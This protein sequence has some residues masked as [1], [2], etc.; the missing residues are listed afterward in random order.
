MTA[1]HDVRAI[2]GSLW[3]GIVAAYPLILVAIVWE[4]VARLGYVRPVFLPPLS[5]V[6]ERIVPM[7]LAGDLLEP[8]LVSLYRAAA[9][10][11]L[12]ILLGVAIGVLMARVR[13]VRWLLDPLVA[14]SFPSPKVAFLPV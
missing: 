14:F 9:G 11:A 5:T 2:A 6:I 3:R 4:G 7:A 8:L 13:L 1:M 10:F 12:A